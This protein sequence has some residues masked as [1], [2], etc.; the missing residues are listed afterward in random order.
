MTNFA[1]VVSRGGP[2]R[3]VSYE[4]FEAETTPHNNVAFIAVETGLAGVLPYIASQLLLWTAFR[5]LRGRG[6]RGRLAWRYFVFIFLAYWISGIDTVLRLLR[7][8]Q[9]LVR[10]RSRA[11]VLL[12]SRDRT[13]S[14]GAPGCRGI[15][16]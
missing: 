2:Y 3:A 13:A 15:E 16:V 5:R 10:L 9:P 6:E 4:G 11:A 14:P 8:S 12:R 1:A 7:R